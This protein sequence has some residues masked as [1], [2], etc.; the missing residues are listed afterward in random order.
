MLGIEKAKAADLSAELRQHVSL[1]AECYEP[2][3]DMD[4][5]AST[6]QFLVFTSLVCCMMSRFPWITE[7]TYK[8]NTINKCIA[9]V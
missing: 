5:K 9:F 2:V 1:Y 8:L 7:E 6:T 3:F 4:S